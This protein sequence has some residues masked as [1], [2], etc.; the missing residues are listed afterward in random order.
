MLSIS[1]LPTPTDVSPLPLLLALSYT[2]LQ[3]THI[4][5]NHSRTDHKLG[6]RVGVKKNLFSSL[7]L[8]RGPATP[9]PPLV[10]PWAIMILGPSFNVAVDAMGSKTDFTLG[11]NRKK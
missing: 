11:T 1:A 10:V 3:D 5:D 6:I 8:L 9:L 4:Q 2:K 7:L